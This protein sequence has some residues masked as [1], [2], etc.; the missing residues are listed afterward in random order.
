VADLYGIS[1]RP[2][3]AEVALEVDVPLFRELLF[4]AIRVLDKTA[5]A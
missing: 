5:P 1:G 2:A 3:N 4:R